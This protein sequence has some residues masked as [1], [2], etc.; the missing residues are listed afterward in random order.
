MYPDWLKYYAFR[1]VLG[2]SSY[3]KEKQAFGKRDKG[4]VA[5]FPDLNRE[6]LA[7]VLDAVEKKA[8]KQDIDT[9]HLEGEEKQQFEK[10]LQG[11]NFAKLYA[12]AIE[13]VT[14]VEENELQTTE[15]EWIKY[16]RDSDHMPLFESLQGHG[17]GWCTAGE[18]TAEI[19]LQAGDFYIF[20]SQDQ[21]G[22]NTIPRAAIRTEYDKYNAIFGIKHGAIAEVRGIAEEQNLDSYIIEVVQKKLQEFPDGK[23]YEKKVFD[24]KQLTEIDQKV[25]TGEELFKEELRFL[26]EFDSPIRGFGFQ[27]DPRIEELLHQRDLKTDAAIVLECEHQYIALTFE[28]INQNTKYYIGSLVPGVFDNINQLEGIYTSFPGENLLENIRQIEI[29]GSTTSELNDKLSEKNIDLSLR[30]K[31]VFEKG[32]ID[33]SQTKEMF[34]VIHLTSSDLGF[35]PNKSINAILSQG[36]GLGLSLCPPEIAPQLFLQQ[37]EAGIPIED[38]YNIAMQPLNFRILSGVIF[39]V[40]FHSNEYNGNIESVRVDKHI[41]PDSRWVFGIKKES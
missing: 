16:D 20:Y 29:G 38:S 1:S 3:D 25:K 34:S 5:P 28:E 26:Y 33:V 11:Q 37:E 36:Q 41:Q 24:M 22:D 32:I 17:T 4:T 9:D 23:E 18:S 2:V 12:W 15:G 30:V 10:L 7:Y 40:N 31:G 8:T 19:Q 14:P 21:D 13:K 6:A 39:R 35:N 27:K